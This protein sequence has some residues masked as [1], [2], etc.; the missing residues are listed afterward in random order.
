MVR[1][2][3]SIS[4]SYIP[5]Q[6]GDLDS[7]LEALFIG[8]ASRQP[9]APLV[10]VPRGT[11]LDGVVNALGRQGFKGAVALH[12]A[13]GFKLDTFRNLAGKYEEEAGTTQP[14][15]GEDT[16]GTGSKSSEAAATA[17]AT[18]AA[19]FS[20]LKSKLPI[21]VASEDTARGLHLP[22]VDV[23]FIAAR[24]RSA[25][26]YVHLA[27]RTGRCGEEG[28]VVSLV[29]YR[30]GKALEVWAK[31]PGFPLERERLMD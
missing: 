21:L 23:V 24:P 30:E 17:A 27:G 16:V 11:A 2:P 28:H 8:L 4:H 20:S 15:L 10:F 19:S 1:V 25:D 9:K 31:Q 14:A 5:C 18:G 22:G 29:S 26:E 13:L 12:E 3:P 6:E 7:K